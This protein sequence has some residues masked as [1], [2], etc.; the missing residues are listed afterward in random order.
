MSFQLAKKYLNG[1]VSAPDV[2]TWTK[3]HKHPCE[4]HYVDA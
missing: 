3:L 2:E 1:G 4:G